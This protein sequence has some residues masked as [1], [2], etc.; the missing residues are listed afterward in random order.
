MFTHLARISAKLFLRGG[1]G[2]STMRR[3]RHGSARWRNARRCGVSIVATQW[4]H[5]AYG[6]GGRRR[7]NEIGEMI[8]TKARSRPTTALWRRIITPA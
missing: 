8:K 2:M 6:V 4:R 7:T 5:P 1:I 3:R